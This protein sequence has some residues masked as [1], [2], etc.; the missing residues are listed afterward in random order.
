[1]WNS[2]VHGSNIEGDIYAVR[3]LYDT[4]TVRIL[5]REVVTHYMIKQGE[6]SAVILS[7]R[8]GDTALTSSL[9]L[10]MSVMDSERLRVLHPVPGEGDRHNSVTGSRTIGL[11][12]RFFLE[13][14]HAQDIDRVR[15]PRSTGR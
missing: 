8:V 5:Q 11:V 2:Y 14:N 10:D 4:C 15:V 9:Q 3:M 7:P 12:R 6:L 13:S 1:M